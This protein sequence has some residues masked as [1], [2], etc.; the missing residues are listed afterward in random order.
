MFLW[1]ECLSGHGG[2][3]IDSYVLKAVS[4]I[5]YPKKRQLELCGLIISLAK[6]KMK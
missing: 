3:E 4:N 6:T 5:K 2:N 1:H